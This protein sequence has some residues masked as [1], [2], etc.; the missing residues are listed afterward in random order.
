MPHKVNP[1]DFENAEG[2]FGVANALLAHMSQKLPISRFQRDLTDSTVLRNMGVAWG[3]SLLG[4]DS[5]GRGLAKLQVD[6]D[7]IGADLDEAWEVL[8]EPIQTVMRRYRLPDAYERLKALT[9]GKT[10]GRDALADFI[11]TLD[12][13]AAERERLLRLTPTAYVGAAARLARDAGKAV[14]FEEDAGAD[15]SADAESPPPGN[16]VPTR[17][18]GAGASSAGEVQPPSARGRR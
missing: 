12:I 1:I 17:A 16:S 7:R 4:Y 2:N 9:R 5:L 18:G 10:I 15:T 11:A 8:A 14:R 3:H 13:P 6:R